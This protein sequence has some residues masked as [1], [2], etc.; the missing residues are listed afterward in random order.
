MLTWCLHRPSSL[1][2]SPGGRWRRRRA[3]PD[4]CRW[5]S[6]RSAMPTRAQPLTVIAQIA[7]A[8]RAGFNAKP[9]FAA[10]DTLDRA[11]AL[12]SHRHRA[13]LRVRRPA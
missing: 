6:M 4:T 13:R 5:W 10:L 7:D 8:V 12:R 3:A 2:H 9:L 1:L 11:S